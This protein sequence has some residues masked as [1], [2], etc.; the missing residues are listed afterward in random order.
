MQAPFLIQGINIFAE[1]IPAKFS[2]P[3]LEFPLFSMLERLFYV[4]RKFPLFSM[5][6]R[7]FYVVRRQTGKVGERNKSPYG[8]CRSTFP[9]EY[10]CPS[11]SFIGYIDGHMSNSAVGRWKLL[12]GDRYN[13]GV[14]Q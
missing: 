9:S 12:G 13:T 8:F 6:E 10:F 2:G 4:V 1:S 7:L 14:L 11:A 5:S 3:V